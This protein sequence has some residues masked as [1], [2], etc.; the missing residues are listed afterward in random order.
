MTEQLPTPEI[1]EVNRA[2]WEGLAQG[3]LQF[4]QCTSCKH[5]WLPARSH[6]PSCL[7]AE[8]TWQQAS[9]RGHVVSWVVYRVAYHDTLKDRVPYDV[10]VVELEEGPRLL[11]NVINSDAG[12]TLDVDATV[13]LVIELEGETHV[14]RFRLV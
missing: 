11:T 8:T 9:G 10:T 7:S 4:Q 12:A 3:R 13:E 14:P 6:C 1:N 5:V 2:Y